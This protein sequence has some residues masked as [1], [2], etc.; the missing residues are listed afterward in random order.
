[1]LQRGLIDEAIM[2]IGSTDIYVYEKI[3]LKIKIFEG[4]K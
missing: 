2:S 3:K 4:I 1:M